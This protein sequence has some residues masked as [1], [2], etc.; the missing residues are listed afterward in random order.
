MRRPEVFSVQEVERLLT[1][2][3]P[4]LRER[5]FLATVYAAGLR[6]NEACHLRVSDIKSERKQIRVEQGKGGKDRYTI[7][8]DRL[9]DLLRQYWRA[10]RPGPGSFPDAGH[11]SSRYWT[12]PHSGFIT[13]RCNEPGCHAGVAFTR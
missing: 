6:L 4:Q 2:G 13:G 10:Y 5:T 11:R 1:K 8:S 7:L 12:P 3:T 9:V